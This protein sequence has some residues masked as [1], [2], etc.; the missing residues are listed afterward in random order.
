MDLLFLVEG[1]GVAIRLR[2]WSGCLRVL[3][4]VFWRLDSEVIVIDIAVS[5]L[6]VIV[7]RRHELVWLVAISFGPIELIDAAI[8]PGVCW[9]SIIILK[10]SGPT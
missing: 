6:V 2:G 1:E 9:S 10:F 5:T 4:V 7:A 3:G 8:E